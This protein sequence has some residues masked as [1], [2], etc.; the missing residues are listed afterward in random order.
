MILS[1]IAAYA[2]DST[3]SLVIGKDNKIPWHYPVDLARFKKFTTGHAVIMGRK[4]YESIG[5]VLPDRTNVI[6]TRQLDYT[7][8]DVHV[9]YDLEAAVEC[10]RIKHAEAFIIGG[11]ELFEQ[12]IGKADRLYL[13]SFDFSDITGDTYFPHYDCTEY[14]IIYTEDS[15]F[16]GNFRILER[17]VDYNGI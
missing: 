14:N 11:Q 1:I 2:E 8:K 5:K 9:F 6:V 15:E 12:T 7:A 16:G 10:A 4:T 17:K 3:G 13:T